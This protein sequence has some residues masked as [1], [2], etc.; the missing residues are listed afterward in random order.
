MN[1]ALRLLTERFWQALGPQQEWLEKPQKV[2]DYIYKMRTQPG[3]IF[4]DAFWETF[5][6]FALK[7]CHVAYYGPERLEDADHRKPYAGVFELRFALADTPACDAEKAV[8]ERCWPEVNWRMRKED[9][10]FVE[11]RMVTMPCCGFSFGDDYTDGHTEAYTCPLCAPDVS[12]AA[13]ALLA[14]EVAAKRLVEVDDDSPTGD[15][16]YR[17]WENLEDALLARAALAPKEK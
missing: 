10:T 2:D 16:W 11:G 4:D 17:A 14:I 3:F 1:E 9:A 13:A 5:H 8:Q 7:I 15:D 12:P 6:G